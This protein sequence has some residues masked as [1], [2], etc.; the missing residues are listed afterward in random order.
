MRSMRRSLVVLMLSLALGVAPLA[1]QNGRFASQPGPAPSFDLTTGLF[2]TAWHALSSLLDKVL[3]TGGD[4]SSSTTQ[5]TP[6]PGTATTGG[7]PTE[8]GAGIDPNG[9]NS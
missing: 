9:V 4:G 6:P 1:A 8:N 2:D 5:S 7:A 3:P